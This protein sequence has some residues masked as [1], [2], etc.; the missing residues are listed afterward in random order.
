[1]RTGL[2]LVI[3]YLRSGNVEVDNYYKGFDAIDAVIRD[4]VNAAKIT[5]VDKTIADFCT[6]ADRGILVNHEDYE[7]KGNILCLKIASVYAKYERWVKHNGTSEYIGRNSFLQ[8]LADKDYFLGK[9]T[10][11]IGKKAC[12]GVKLDLCSLPEEIDID[13]PGYECFEIPKLRAV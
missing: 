13:W 10:V 7:I 8:Q 1:M 5:N 11:K 12:H 6:M 3:D 2:W 9:K 4:A